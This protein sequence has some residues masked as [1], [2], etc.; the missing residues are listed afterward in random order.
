MKRH[1]VIVLIL[2]LT[3]CNSTGDKTNAAGSSFGSN[4]PAWVKSG[5]V[6]KYPSSQ[7]ITGLGYSTNNLPES[8]ALAQARLQAFKDISDQIE[9]HIS[10]EFTAIQRS[11]FH[12]EDEDEV[13]DFKSV[14][15]QV[16]EELLAGA[17]VVDRYYEGSSG[18]AAVFAVMDRIKLSERL[19]K[20]AQSARSAIDGYIKGYGE[21]AAKVD[22]SAML[23]NLVHAQASFDK[24]VSNHLKALAVGMTREMSLS[25]EKLNDAA[26]QAKITQDLSAVKDKTR[27]AT[28][29]GNEQRATLEGFLKEPV[30]LRALWG[31]KPVANFPVSV[32]VEDETKAKVVLEANTTD[33]EGRFSFQLQG[34]KATGWPNNVVVVALDF[35]ALEKKN[36]VTPPTLDI[37][38]FFPT[39]DT[40]R[41]GV[42]IHETIDGKE[43]KRPHTES[44]IKD[45][46]TDIGFQVTILETDAPASKV[47]EMPLSELTERFAGQCEYLIV[48]T[49][50]AVKQSADEGIQWYMTRLIIDAI[51]LETAKTIHFEV[52]MGQL[53]KSGHRTEDRASRLSLQKAAGVMVDKPGL[54]AKKFIARFE[55]GGEWKED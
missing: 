52:P 21:A 20:E 51:E 29:S 3:A 31:E 35:A 17:E 26:L 10:S 14:S 38:Y 8:D 5:Q 37:T 46:L 13:V 36:K 7:Y 32:T 42:V 1:I 44:A 4:A 54:L 48:G 18:T 41:V 23:K 40:T 9:T 25:F 50:E 16:T 47:V 49:A 28:V 39:P 15:K 53:T 34:L 43:N 55:E 27:I 12:N 33:A 45:A 19:L 24:I 22:P 30:K 6:P 2:M 11:V